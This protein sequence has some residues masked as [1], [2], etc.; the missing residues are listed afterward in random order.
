MKRPEADWKLLEISH[1]F[2]LSKTVYHRQGIR[3]STPEL[4]K[5]VP[6]DIII[7][8]PFAKLNMLY[9]IFL[10]PHSSFHL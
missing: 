1:L 9:I 2:L 7:I 3:K 10:F 5:Y 6:L 8:F 4:D